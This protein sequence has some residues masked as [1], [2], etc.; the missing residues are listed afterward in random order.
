[1]AERV[2]SGLVPAEDQADILVGWS[3]PP[4]SALSRTTDVMVKADKILRDLKVIRTAT[5]LAGQD[6]LSNAPKTYAG[7]AFLTLSDWSERTR[8]EEEARNLVAPIRRALSNLRE[9]QFL[10]FNPPP[11]NG[12]DAVDGFEFHLLDQQGRGTAALV[13]VSNQ[14]IADAATR[15][16]LGVLSASLQ[17]DTPRYQVDVDRNRAKVLGISISSIFDTVRST[18]GALYVNDFPLYGRNYHVNLQSDAAFRHDPADIRQVFVRTDKGEM[19]PLSAVLTLRRVIGADAIEHFNVWPS[20]VVIG[21][22]AP[23][24]SSGQAITA[25]E[26]LA[27]DKLPPGYSLAWAGKAFQEKAVGNRSWQAAGLGIVVVFLILA[28]LYERWTLALAVLMVV[29]LALFGALLLVWLRGM[30]NDIY[31]QVGLVTLIGLSAKNAVLIVEFASQRQ[32]EGM[33]AADAALAALRLRF[34]PVVMTSSAFILGCMPLAFSVG[35]GAGARRS[36]GTGVIG[37]MLGATL[38][39]VFLLPAFYRIVAGRR[40]FISSSNRATS[41]TP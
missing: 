3:L 36:I 31:F 19:V 22:A 38:L 30:D 12:L 27:R 6:L 24:Y 8:S 40:H 16:E 18:F 39:A 32:R 28:A 26:A 11:I 15:P 34:R 1:M 5:M 10:V 4:G 35:A 29:P 20:T 17:A 2:P 25:I 14:F 37:G 13:A 41:A 23:G 21:S 7:L 33:S 9:A